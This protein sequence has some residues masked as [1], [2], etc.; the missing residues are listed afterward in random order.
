MAS[1]SSVNITPV[2]LNDMSVDPC[3]SKKR[4]CG[5]AD[6]SE[7]EESSD[8]DVSNDH[9]PNNSALSGKSKSKNKPKRARSGKHRAGGPSQTKAKSTK[10]TLSASQIE[11]IEASIS[12]VIQQSQETMNLSYQGDLENF[13]SSG[14]CDQKLQTLS[15]EVKTLANTVARQSCVINDLHAKLNFVLS[16]LD[17]DDKASSGAA[18]ASSIIS[19]GPTNGN[20]S[21]PS[22]TST[23]D[24]TIVTKPLFSE[25][26]QTGLSS[27][28]THSD[29]QQFTNLKHSV[30]SAV[31]EDLHSRESR[32]CNVVV[33]GLEAEPGVDDGE[34]V[35]RLCQ[36]EF[37]RTPA[38]VKCFRL[39][40]RLPNRVRPLLVVLQSRFEAASLT[41]LDMDR[42]RRGR[43]GPYK[44]V[45]VNPDLTKAEADA[46][47]NE[48]VKRR[49]RVQQRGNVRSATAASTTA[50]PAGSATAMTTLPVP[51]SGR[52]GFGSGA[53]SGAGN[54]AGSSSRSG[55]G[56]GS[57]SGSGPGSGAGA[58]SGSDSVSD[59][60]AGADSGATV[61]SFNVHAPEFALHPP[62]STAA[63][64]VA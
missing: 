52:A 25:V 23:S 12:S 19:H 14:I 40:R 1:M 53:G 61:A 39:G 10:Q 6:L 44:S 24:P 46:A 3:S 9:T 43:T 27:S 2:Q 15:D 58:G 57:S 4:T 11:S 51:P 31:Y 50:N 54:G 29:K 8:A 20:T 45:Y 32:V 36:T 17:I 7:S 56:S 13:H 22:S 35:R 47:Y 37:G 26:L 5:N 41:Q 28:N 64:S 34:A 59:S 60:G 62:T 42:G 38:V 33:S 63:T 16:F 48:R 21:F 18:T 49:Q 30:M 55:S